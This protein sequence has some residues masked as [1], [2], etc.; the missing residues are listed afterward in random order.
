MEMIPANIGRFGLG[1]YKKKLVLIPANIKYLV[2]V[3]GILF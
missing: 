3:I 2:V 1:P